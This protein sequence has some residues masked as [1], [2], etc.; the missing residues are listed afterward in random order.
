MVSNSVRLIGKLGADATLF[1]EK[2]NN[3]GMNFSLA[4]TRISKSGDEKTTETDWH[5]CKFYGTVAQSKLIK[6]GNTIAIEGSLGY[7]KYTNAEG[8]EIT[9]TVIYVEEFFLAATPK[10]A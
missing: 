6:K 7:E 10:E 5:N 9:K 8:T 1:N 4:T 3:I 2:E